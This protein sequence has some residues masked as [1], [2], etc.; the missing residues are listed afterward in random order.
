[1]KN[2]P[3]ILALSATAISLLVFNL[4]YWIFVITEGNILL[5]LFFVGNTGGI[6]QVFWSLASILQIASIAMCV[7]VFISALQSRDKGLSLFAIFG[8]V[9]YF[10]SALFDVFAQVSA[11]WWEQMN[12]T[13]F[14]EIKFRFIGQY[15]DSPDRFGL[16]AYFQGIFTFAALI[17]LMITVVLGVQNKSSKTNSTFLTSVNLST[18]Q[19]N[20]QTKIERGSA[21]ESDLQWKV[22]LPGQPDQ[23]VDTATLQMWAR[24]GV[25]RPDTLILDV[26]NNMTYAASQIPNV[27]SPKSYVTALLLSFFL[28]AIGVDRFYLGQ[29]GLGIGKLLT[30]GGC[31]VWALIDFILIAMR[32]VTDSQGNPLA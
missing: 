21:M 8:L 19:V 1:M 3:A 14:D 30:L 16:F 12:S 26:N 15:I 13:F 31:G 29:T 2:R 4:F 20:T 27:F 17:G 25:I 7:I 5:A 11:P 10:L 32:K 18:N 23:A 24:S 9:S 22:K 6:T 28:G